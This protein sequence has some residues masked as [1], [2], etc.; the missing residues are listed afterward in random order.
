MVDKEKVRVFESTIIMGAG[1]ISIASIPTANTSGVGHEKRN[2]AAYS[3]YEETPQMWCGY[4]GDR[5][6]P[7][8]MV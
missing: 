7:Y 1:N 5:E 6:F 3:Q 2:I 8:P 4:L